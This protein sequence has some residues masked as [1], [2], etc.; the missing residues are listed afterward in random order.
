MKMGGMTMMACPEPLMTQ[1]KNLLDAL[2]AV[3]N[4]RIEGDKLELRK[5]EQLLARFEAR[6]R[7]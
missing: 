2:Q 5:G 7:K 3:S 6:A 4:Y 1:E